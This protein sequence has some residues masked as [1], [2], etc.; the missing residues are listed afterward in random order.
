MKLF[1]P[2]RAQSA[3][4]RFFW[5]LAV[6]SAGLSSGFGGVVDSLKVRTPLVGDTS[7]QIDLRM[8][9]SAVVDPDQTTI[10]IFDGQ[11]YLAKTGLKQVEYGA[12]NREDI[13]QSLTTKRQYA[14]PQVE[15]LADSSSALQFTPVDPIKATDLI[16]AKVFIRESAAVSRTAYALSTAHVDP[17]AISELTVYYL[18]QKKSYSASAKVSGDVP[19]SQVE[20]S[21]IGAAPASIIQAGGRLDNVSSLLDKKG[22]IQLPLLSDQKVFSSVFGMADGAVMPS[23]ALLYLMVTGTDV[24]GNVRSHSEVF[25]VSNLVPLDIDRIEATAGTAGTTLSGFGDH[26]QVL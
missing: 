2:A 9:S 13:L 23:G 17:P 25:P 6:A 16:Y 12:V 5:L 11:E 26:R 8:A 1:F 3:L 20:I 15:T 24:L 18:P 19:V 14:S 22:E 21:M 4:V 10:T 7:V